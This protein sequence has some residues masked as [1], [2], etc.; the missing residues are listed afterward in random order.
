MLTAA[1]REDLVLANQ[2]AALVN[3]RLGGLERWVRAWCVV[4]DAYLREGLLEDAAR[5]VDDGLT[6]W[7]WRPVRGAA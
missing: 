1:E 3:G 7:R 4:S 5:C 6:M 2:A